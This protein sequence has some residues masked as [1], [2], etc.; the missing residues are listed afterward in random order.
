MMREKKPKII[1]T[2]WVH[3]DV[4]DYLNG[5]ADVIANQ[6]RTTP[7]TAADIVER[8]A[9]AEALLA[10]MTDTVD[11]ALLE[12]LPDLRMISCAV[13]GYDNF[14]VDA[15]A[16]RGVEVAHVPDLLQEPTA[17]LTLGL[18]IALTRNM[19]AAD[20]FVRSG[21]FS[22]WRPHFYGLG[23]AGT[24]VGVI[25][26]GGLGQAIARRLLACGAEISF[27][28]DNPGSVPE[29]FSWRLHAC[30][31][32]DVLRTS[33]ILI[34]ALPLTAGTRHMIGAEALSAM[35]AGAFLINPARGSL[36][37]E[38][39]IA[40]ALK[41]G[42]LAGYAADVFAL[43]DWALKDRPKSIPRDLIEARDRTVFTPHLGSAVD[44]IRRDIAMAAARHIRQFFEGERPD[45]LVPVRQA[46][47]VKLSAD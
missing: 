7:W 6:D 30:P 34:L 12:R 16:A 39:A 23:L 4:R 38:P 41:T 36:V 44:S 35:P 46:H 19:L 42:Q 2:N 24:P 18:I 21:H 10:F 20:R 31:L 8:G 11:A 28:D 33:R 14:D 17:D 37:D 29:E 27:F 43:E 1:V 15:C 26:M 32:G 40:D 9:G 45:G 22:G 3:D 25:G 5:F 13:R 47:H